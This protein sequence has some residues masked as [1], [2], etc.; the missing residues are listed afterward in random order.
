MRKKSEPIVLNVVEKKKKESKK[1]GL[2][3][4]IIVFP[5]IALMV[6][7][8]LTWGSWKLIGGLAASSAD[9]VEIQGTK[10]AVTETVTAS[11]PEPTYKPTP[12]PVASAPAE[13]E[14][15]QESESK[16]I[17]SK[18]GNTVNIN[19]DVNVSG[20]NNTVTVTNSVNV[21]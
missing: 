13:E 19:T 8:L 3:N 9:T 1:G 17:S 20:E 7:G 10:S 6:F 15:I 21:E 16:T 11:T 12:K 14:T 2:I 18:K 5:A 4:P